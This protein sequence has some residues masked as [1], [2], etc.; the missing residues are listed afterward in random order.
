MKLAYPDVAERFVAIEDI[1]AVAVTALTTTQY[2]N[3][4]VTIQGPAGSS[5]R[6][7]LQTISHL[8][9]KP[10]QVDTV[11]EDEFKQLM[12]TIPPIT[13][14]MHIAKRFRAERGADWQ[15][16]TDELVTGGVTFEQFIA[17]HKHEFDE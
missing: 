4:A 16:P 1:A 13:D 17:Q 15:A 9:G 7:Q 10:I 14:S 2:D 3:K 5:E 6:E 12:I 8:L 11:S